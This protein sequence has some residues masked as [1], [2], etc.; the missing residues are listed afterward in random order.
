MNSHDQ[1]RLTQR[2]PDRWLAVLRIAVG[3]WFLKSVTTKLSVFFALGIIPLPTASERWINFLPQRLLDYAGTLQIDWYSNFLLGTVIPNAQVFAHFTAFGE[4]VV[5]LG[6]TLGLVTRA[7]SAVG[8]AIMANYLLA[9]F[10]VGF[11]QQGFHMLLIA[12]MIA[13]FVAGAGR[14]WGLDGWLTERFPGS[15]LARWRL[16]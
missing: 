13:F 8:L 1:V 15:F 16:V 6:L 4:A 9:T 11:C 10:W 2:H 5:G 14:T 12:C 3:L 7:T